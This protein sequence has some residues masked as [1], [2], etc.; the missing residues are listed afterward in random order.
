MHGGG[1]R[2]DFRE[3]EVGIAAA[4]KT[5]PVTLGQRVSQILSPDSKEQKLALS[6]ESWKSLSSPKGKL[7]TVD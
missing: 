1:D 2:E 6:A 4:L 3:V 7:E 5:A